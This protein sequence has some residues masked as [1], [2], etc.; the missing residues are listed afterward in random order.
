MYKIGRKNIKR[1]RRKQ[2]MYHINILIILLND[3]QAK[4][5][6]MHINEPVAI[7]HVTRYNEN[8]MANLNP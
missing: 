7:K 2:A 8:S 6:L 3:F 5:T 1:S 4:A